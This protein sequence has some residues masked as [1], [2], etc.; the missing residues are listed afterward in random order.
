MRA[1]ER[2]RNSHFPKSAMSAETAALVTK[3][4]RAEREN[5]LQRL[6]LF[7][8]VNQL[9]WLTLLFTVIATLVAIALLPK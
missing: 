6:A 9:W 2:L 4:L 3:N 7:F 5:R 1:A 8:E